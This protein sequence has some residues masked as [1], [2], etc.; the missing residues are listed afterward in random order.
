M[1]EVVVEVVRDGACAVVARREGGPTPPDSARNFRPSVDVIGLEL[2]AQPGTRR[3][4][5]ATAIR[6][7]MFLW[8]GARRSRY[9]EGRRE[10]PSILLRSSGEPWHTR[11]ERSPLTARSEARA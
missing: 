9:T 6:P 10:K 4:L 2:A 5:R 3:R 1:T 11:H 7:Y 8:R